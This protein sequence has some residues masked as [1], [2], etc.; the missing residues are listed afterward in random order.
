MDTDN[1]I[2]YEENEMPDL[3]GEQFRFIR[4]SAGI[5]QVVFA[6]FVHRSAVTIRRE[7]LKERVRPLF[8]RGLLEFINDPSFVNL[9]IRRWNQQHE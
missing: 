2:Y 6:N 9:I 8:I 5:S 7:E 3:T 1:Q 4:Q